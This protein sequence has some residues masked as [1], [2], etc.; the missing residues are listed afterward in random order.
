MSSESCP[1]Q[2]RTHCPL[3]P[4]VRVEWDR[5]AH[6]IGRLDVC[7]ELGERVG[8]VRV[9]K[10]APCVCRKH[11][12]AHTFWQHVP[13]GCKSWGKDWPP[14]QPNCKQREKKSS[15][16]S[17]RPSWTCRRA[18]LATDQR[19]CCPAAQHA[20]PAAQCEA[21]YSY[22]YPTFEGFEGRGCGGNQLCGLTLLDVIP[23]E[24]DFALGG[25][26]GPSGTPGD[27]PKGPRAGPD[28]LGV[29]G[30]PDTPGDGPVAHWSVPAVDSEA[31]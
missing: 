30:G 14:A 28:H 19:C 16:K 17:P 22:F 13:N 15:R 23:A 25:P 5:D 29:P 31:W 9:R 11:P 20:G 1:R 2:P 7:N 6:A 21:R 3:C 18:R 8:W 4:Q 24:R 10:V 12:L 26:A 27:H